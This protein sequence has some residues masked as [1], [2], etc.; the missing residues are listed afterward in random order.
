MIE[1]YKTIKEIGRGSNG[2]VYLVEKD[3]KQFALKIEHIEKSDISTFIYREKEFSNFMHN[4]YPAFFMELYENDIISNC[5]HEQKRNTRQ[6]KLQRRSEQKPTTISNNENDRQTDNKKT[7]DKQQDTNDNICSRKIF[8]LVTDTF[9]NVMETLNKQ[10]IYSMII[11]VTYI[12]HLIHLNGY[13]HGDF[14]YENLGVIKTDKVYLQ[15]NGYQIPTFGYVYQLIDYY[16]VLNK[17]YNLTQQET[18]KFKS[19]F[20][21]ER[22][23]AIIRLC[24]KYVKLGKISDL[25]TKKIQGLKEYD[26]VKKCTNNDYDRML[27][28]KFKYPL[29]YQRTV[30]GSNFKK[31]ETPIMFIT[32]DDMIFILNNYYN[33][34]NVIK[35]FYKKIIMTY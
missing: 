28:F 12:L 32:I 33:A 9:K 31:V 8:S 18:L 3:N 29:L 24:T 13:V 14:H 23:Y 1:D 26:S 16:N 7:E 6:T 2:T 5:K 34:I 20:Q 11:Q 30:L 27:I 21:N 15:I 17:K 22:K 19:A 4:K 35:Y 25:V 10:Q